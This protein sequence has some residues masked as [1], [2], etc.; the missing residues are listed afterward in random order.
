MIHP[1]DEQLNDYVEQAL[2][3]ADHVSVARHVEDCAAC[4]E[5]VSDLQDII[6]Y[7]KAMPFLTPPAGVWE[8]IESHSSREGAGSAPAARHS[9]SPTGWHV[10]F[11]P[12]WALATA[13]LLIAAFVT[14]RV[15]EHRVVRPPAAVDSQPPYVDATPAANLRERV[16]L[17]AVGDHL[18]RSQMVLLGLSNAYTRGALDISV[19]Q[20]SAGELLASNR[21]LRQTAAQ[22]GQTS[23]ADVL[24]DLE[25]VLAEV[26]NAPSHMKMADLAAIQQRIEAESILF[27]VKIIRPQPVS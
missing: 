18:E 25:R 17:V 11:P 22:T 20:Q 23:V 26:A 2:S 8:H 7:A 15:V 9:G 1:T 10:P 6:E 27:K 5:V 4:A 14:G 16:L 3:P 13:A 21:L 19:E 12:A 24:D